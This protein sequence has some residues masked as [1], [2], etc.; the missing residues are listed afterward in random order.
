MKGQKTAVI[1]GSTGNVGMEC[2]R[3]FAES[4]FSVLGLSRHAPAG[5][6]ASRGRWRQC[7]VRD[8]RAFRGLLTDIWNENGSMDAM[9]Y[10]AG[11]PPDA[12]VC[13]AEYQIDAWHEACDVYITGFLVAF[14]E[15]LRLMMPGGH[16]IAVSSAVT[17][18]SGE[19]LPPLFV[20]HYAAT[21]AALNELCKWGR[22]EANSHGLLL[23]RIAPGALD[24]PYHRLA[25]KER[26]PPAVLPVRGIAEQIVSAVTEA[27]ELDLEIVASPAR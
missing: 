9:V 24:V 11:L 18:F 14:Q 8:E 23:S 19:R 17:R 15:A 2:E 3:C 21:K 22:R 4:G 27:R 25:P 6:T 12:D 26:R 10:T 16:I 13:L 5:G 7:N 1:V 20:G